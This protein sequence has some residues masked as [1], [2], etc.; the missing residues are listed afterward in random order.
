M[1]IRELVLYGY[2]GKVR[3]LPFN[4]GAVNVITGKS[5]SGKSAVGDIIEYCLG[6]DSCPIADG[7]VRE[8]VAWYGL[9]LQFENEQVFVARKN[10]E[11]GQQSTSYCYME[12]GYKITVP[13]SCDFKPN[14]NV[15][16]LETAL[17]QR[18]GISENQHTPPI[19]QS[20]APLSAN[21]RH[22]LF[23]CFQSQDEIAGR[24]VLFHRQAEDFMTQTIKDTL[25]YFLGVVNENALLLESERSNLR[26]Q[27]VLE[28][29]KLNETKSIAGG[30]TRALSLLSE[31]VQVGLV[32]NEVYSAED[33][34]AVLYATLKAATEW[35]P[36]PIKKSAMDRLS[37][38]QSSLDECYQELSDLE[39]NIH[40]A[41][42][43]SGETNGFAAEV[44]HQKTRLESIGLFEKLNFDPKV[45]PFCAGSLESPLPEVEMIKAAIVNLDEAITGV[46]KEQPKL[47]AFIDS[48]ESSRQKKREEIANLEAE[49][50]GIYSQDDAA[51]RVRDLN[52]RRAMVVGRISLWMDSVDDERDSK[53]N[54]DRLKKIEA[55]L[56]E[57]DTLLDASEAEE[58]KQSIL[59]RIQVNMTEWAKGLDLEH[60]DNPYRL[61]LNKVTV[62]VDKPD[63]PV[64]L[65]Q[66]GSGANWVGVHLITYFALQKHFIEAQRPVP[67][68]MFLDQPSQVYFPSA[69]DEKK[70]DWERVTE[71]YQFILDRVQ[72]SNGALQAIIVDHANP[73]EL[74]FKGVVVENWQ[75]DGYLVPEDW[76]KSSGD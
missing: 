69:L 61:D 76:Y 58:K 55:R 45:C 26:R 19:G 14:T 29:R 37:Y 8:N 16:S 30:R 50:D 53:P 59:A 74:G 73:E 34:Y 17:S 24:N 11:L 49:I 38:L 32:D 60:H 66:L 18:L 41:K 13:A 2:N 23:Y 70:T 4:I 6:G 40:N 22:S 36:L 72:Q 31:A 20:R 42:T 48:L 57:I 75:D 25:P 63:R 52:S 1:Q 10:P 21:I 12:T 28:K 44:V 43:F 39:L 71:I 51:L 33:D 9:L 3:H 56:A 68:F 35:K 62:I 27:V 47:R 15:S 65:R 67:R 5:K 64:S 54:E 46:T 7:V